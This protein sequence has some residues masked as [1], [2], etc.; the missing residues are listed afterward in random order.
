MPKRR[1]SRTFL[2]GTRYWADFRDYAD[3]GGKVEALKAKGEPFATD[4][5]DVAAKLASDKVEELEGLR[6]QSSLLGIRGGAELASYASEHLVHKREEGTSKQ[7]LALLEAYLR[8]AVESFGAGRDLASIS[9]R[10]VAE[11]VRVLQ[12][13]P[14]GRG[15]A[16]LTDATVRKYLNALSDLYSRAV[17]DGHA[18]LNPARALYKK[19]TAARKVARYFEP[20]EVAALLESARAI[21]SDPVHT[22]RGG[23]GKT[24][25]GSYPW[26]YPLLATAALTGA[27]KTELF[28]LEVDDVSFK[29][30]CIFI[31]PN[32]WRT[33]KTRGSERTIPLWPQLEEILRAYLLARE[34]S[35]GLGSLLFPTNRGKE[36]GLLDNVDRL[37]DRIGERAGIAK[38]RLHAFRHSYTAARIQTLEKGAPVHM[39]QVARELGH[40]SSSMIED[41]YGHLARVTER[42]EV[43][44]F[45]TLEGH[46]TPIQ[47]RAAPRLF[48]SS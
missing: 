25:A 20:A 44:V 14:S 23:G 36:E 27:R 18:M 4:D 42:S 29:L 38:P 12:R 28:G 24:S 6:R 9:T 3:V 41:R 13:R 43:V 10:E 7:H 15:D 26:I 21:P 22:G 1:T 8:V 47:V 32:Q 11:W 39:W 31:R 17:S 34:Q 16:T 5:P 35:G 48:S 2:R 40:Q 33:L 30:G 19:P 37:M 45:K 46:A